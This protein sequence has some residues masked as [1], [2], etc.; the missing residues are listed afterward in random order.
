MHNEKVQKIDFIYL[1]GYIFIP[2]LI[3]TI[4]FELTYLFFRHG[5]VGAVI[6]SL[7]PPLLAMVWWIFAGSF[8]FRRH[9]KA[10][11]KEFSAAGYNRNNT[12]YGRGKTVI[13]DID[14]GMLGI[15]FFWNPWK[16]YILP[17][18]RISKAWTDNGKHG[19]GIMEGSQQVS[20]LFVIDDVTVRVNTF[21][22]N[23]RF[24]MDDKH[25]LTGISKA[26]MMVQG[27]EDAKKNSKAGHDNKT[28]SS[29]KT[30]SSKSDDKSASKSEKSSKS[31][32]KST[33]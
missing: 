9:T 17:A 15:C 8:I 29:A 22:S 13:L 16:S 7:V 18:S 24:R 31:S 2:I 25:I 33:K 28:D 4:G 19:A 6:T 21:S 32:S 20:F 12:F 30:K 11:E 27:I 5:G 14:H 3:C 10:F 1:I 26:D 23:Q